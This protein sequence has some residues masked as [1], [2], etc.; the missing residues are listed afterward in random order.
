MSGRSPPLYCTFTL[1]AIILLVLLGGVRINNIH[2]AMII[3]IYCCLLEDRVVDRVPSEHPH[4]GEKMSK[5]L[6][7]IIGCEDKTFPLV[8]LVNAGP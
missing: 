7:G 3:T 6:G 4:R 1:I 8:F 2:S 5:R